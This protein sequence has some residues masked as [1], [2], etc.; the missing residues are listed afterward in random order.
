MLTATD[1]LINVF[2]S[3]LTESQLLCAR[4]LPKLLSPPCKQRDISYEQ[5]S[6]MLTRALAVPLP[7]NMGHKRRKGGVV[8]RWRPMEALHF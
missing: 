5:T 3:R 4:F 6:S 8:G 1:P 7:G 2:L